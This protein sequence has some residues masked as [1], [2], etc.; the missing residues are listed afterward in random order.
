MKWTHCCFG[1]V[2]TCQNICLKGKK[3]TW[4]RSITNQM[5]DQFCLDSTIEYVTVHFWPVWLTALSFCCTSAY[6]VVVHWCI[7]RGAAGRKCEAE[8]LAKDFLTRMQ[9]LLG[10][11]ELKIESQHIWSMTKKWD[12]E[13]LLNWWYRRSMSEA[14]YH[15]L[16]RFISLDR[17]ETTWWCL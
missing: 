11:I 17:T 1:F 6:N 10:R 4:E 16:A 12:D 7:Y 2:F 3:Y 5:T 15:V 13:P 8:R 9:R 14:F